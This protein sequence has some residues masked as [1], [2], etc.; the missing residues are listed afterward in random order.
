MWDSFDGKCVL[1]TGG[2]GFL[3]TAVVYRLVTRTSVSLIYILCRGGRKALYT[4]WKKSLPDQFADKLCRSNRLLVLDGNIIKPNMGLSDSQVDIV[5]EDVEIVIHAA[6][7]I[8]LTSNLS[9]LAPTVIKA[10]EIVAQFALA[11][12]FLT[13][14]VYVSSAYANAHLDPRSESIDVAVQEKIYPPSQQDTALTEWEEVQKTGTSS[15]YDTEDYPW[16]YAYAKHLTERLL[17]RMF[18]DH[19]VTECLLIVRPS[20]IGPAQKCPYPGYCVPCSTPT[21]SAAVSFLLSA[22]SEIRTTTRC[23][24][25]DAEVHIDEVPVDVVADRLLSHLAVGTT[26]CVHAVSGK[27][28]R[29]NYLEW[30]QPIMQLRRIPWELKRVW[31]YENWKT[32]NQHPISRLWV[33]LGS[34]F[35]FSEDRTIAI[36]EELAEH[37]DCS[38][39]QLFTTAHMGRQLLERTQQLRSVMDQIAAHSPRDAE[40]IQAYYQ[41]FG[42]EGVERLNARL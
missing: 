12:S 32:P 1:I 16:S 42:R 23:P 24:D 41:D 5:R 2:S 39:L 31:I 34:S 27:R 21:T 14:F 15:V 25:P 36:S 9:S 6:S 11:C 19:D 29:T 33:A 26:G 40:I 3:G 18:N 10:T 17:F 35:C 28:A 37:G 30:W 4:R 8:N 7:S 20:I 38:D 22:D 13:R